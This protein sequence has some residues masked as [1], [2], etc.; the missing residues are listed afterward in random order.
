M[1]VVT[2]A[3]HEAFAGHVTPLL[4]RR[5]AE[6]N[7][8]LGRISE[9]RGG[10][11]PPPGTLFFAVEGGDGEAV[12]AGLMAPPNPLVMTR[13][14]D[15]AIDAL[16]KYLAATGVRPRA[17]SAP[18]ATARGFAR[19]WSDAI[20]ARVHSE[21][22]VGLFQLTELVPPPR[23]APGRFRRAVEADFDA[24]VP[25]A[26]AF[27]REISHFTPRDAGSVVAERIR[28]DRLFFW[29]D[30]SDRPVSMAGWAGRTPNGVR[31]NF[32]Y[33]PPEFRN[34][35]YATS[36]VAALT[37][38][39]LDSGR[40]FCFLFTDLANPTSNRIYRQIGYQ[41]VCDMRDVRFEPPGDSRHH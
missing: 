7:F 34:R 2:F 19:V 33:S 39:L 5:E 25:W 16:V 4:M 31:I 18:E 12:A 24:I 40:K 6:N 9:F 38:H 17:V 20:G 1:R 37:K 23:P 27:F 13:E 11:A 41:H 30:P 10:H 36:C 29:C 3:D 8:L 22:G 15:E 26:A 21:F 35:G 32:V 28:E 14:D